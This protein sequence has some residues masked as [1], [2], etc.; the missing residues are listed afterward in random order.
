MRLYQ[1]I[2]HQQPGN[3]RLERICSRRVATS[4]WPGM[5]GLFWKQALSTGAWREDFLWLMDADVDAATLRLDRALEAM[6]RAEV[7]SLEFR[8]LHA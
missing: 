8:L 1:P 7:Q 2:R 4:R 3:G 6:R 5:K